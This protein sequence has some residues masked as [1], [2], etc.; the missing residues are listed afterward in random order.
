MFSIQ[1]LKMVRKLTDS[2]LNQSVHMP[3]RKHAHKASEKNRNKVM[4]NGG[5]NSVNEI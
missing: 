4:K 2:R 3:N 1:N 5:K